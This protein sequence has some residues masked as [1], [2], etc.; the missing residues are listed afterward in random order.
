MNKT[1]LERYELAHTIKKGRTDNQLVRNDTLYPHWMTYA[2]GADSHYCWY[3]R[4]TATGRE[5]RLLDAV[6]S[7]NELAFDHHVLANLLNDA[8]L[9]DLSTGN[10]NNSSN[11]L[12][13]INTKM[14]EQA[15]DPFDLPF[16]FVTISAEKKRESLSG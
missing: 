11:N 3:R 12:V 10:K 9:T 7:S 1:L 16:T 5:Y 15:V 6:T 2:D 14:A 4:M 8:L 13:D